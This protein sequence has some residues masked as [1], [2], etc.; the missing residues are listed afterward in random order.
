MPRARTGTLLP[1][2][3]DGLWRARV[4]KPKATSDEAIERPLY[5]LGTTDKALARRKLARLVAAIDRGEDVLDAAETANSA[6][7]VREYAD[8]WLAKREAQGVG[9]V[10]KE[11]RTLELYAFGTIGWLPLCDV[12]PA[13]IRSI[14]DDAA[15]E[16][17]KRASV[18][19]VRGV[20]NRMFRAALESELIES[21]PVVAVR[22]PRMRE[23]KKARLILTD[24]EVATFIACAAVDL[25]LRMLSLVARCEGGMRTGDLHRWD[26]TQIDCVEF[27]E[28]FIPRSKTLSPQRLAIPNTL[29]PYLRGWWERAGKPE[30]GPVFPARTGKRAGQAKAADNSYASRLRRDLFRAGVYRLKPVEVPATKPGMRTDLKKVPV[31]TKLAP[32]PHDPLYNDTESTLR[33]DFHSFRRSFSSALADA[34]VNVQHAMHLTAHSDPRVHSRYVMQTL[35]MRTI[36]EAALPRLHAPSFAELPAA[37]VS[38]VG[39]ACDPL[40]I[41]TACDDS[42]FSDEEDDDSEPVSTRLLARILAPTVGL[43]PTTRRLTAACS[44]N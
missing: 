27:A 33:V 31:G 14:L 24:E 18:G 22:M 6:E 43:E 34:G 29:A 17:R 41:V 3:A 38:P 42:S 11:R 26:W 8:A 10:K 9:M 16:G 2:G 30:S 32:H 12:R 44:T 37:D 23:V 35:A 21:N 39:V 36:P 7:R 19:H 4:T 25:E 28:C 13:H 40:G 20:L 15:A 5:S 1:P